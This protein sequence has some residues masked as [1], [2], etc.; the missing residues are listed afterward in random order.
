MQVSRSVRTAVVALV[1][2]GALAACGSSG[3]GS[4]AS[5]PTTASPEET[6][7]PAAQVTAGLAAVRAIAQGLPAALA[8]D[9]TQ[10]RKDVDRMYAKWFTFEGTVR[11]NAQDLYLTMEDG[12]SGMKVGVQ[13]GKPD[14]VT[15]GLADF[16]HAADAYVKQ[17]P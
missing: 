14:R 9:E 15:S 1:V 13:T 8:A 12:L 17:H 10:A 3:G 7:V 2:A 6:I 11:K 4:S 16:E 5:T